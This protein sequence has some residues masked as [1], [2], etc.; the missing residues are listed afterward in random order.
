MAEKTILKS[1]ISSQKKTLKLPGAIGDWTTYRPAK[2]LIKKVKS[3]LYG[4][5]RISREELNTVLLIHYRFIQQLLKRVKIDLGLSG[6]LLQ[7]QVEQVS[8][9]NFLR[10][11]G[12]AIV[13]GQLALPEKHESI[14]FFLDLN[15]ANS[16]INHALGSRDLDAPPRALTEAEVATLTIALNEYLPLFSKTFKDIFPP[17]SFQYLSSPDAGIDPAF[18]TS[19]TFI[20]FSAEL[21]LNDNPAGKIIF[22]YQGQALKRLIKNYQEKERI[23]PLDL[24]RLPLAILNKIIVPIK[25]TLGETSLLTSEIS[26]LEVG[27]VVSLDTS[28]EEA[29]PLTIGKNL[30]VLAQ[31]GINRRKKAVKILGLTDEYFSFT[32]PSKISNEEEL[33][34]SSKKK[35]LKP[36]PLTSLAAGSAEAVQTEQPTT[37]P[38]SEETF[39]DEDFSEE[40]F[41]ET[42]FEDEEEGKENESVDFSGEDDDFS[43]EEDFPEEEPK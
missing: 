15:L 42:S 6:E 29:I 34:P 30:K 12:T 1:E 37:L 4:F 17:P 9:L 11:L 26:Q 19:A 10:S 31:P 3:G 5:D 23:A 21:T 14:A 25:A 16:L 24:S 18:N 7:C 33:L 36:S 8:Y 28:I 35:E 20:A 27:D 39:S 13:Q 38:A 43:L 32:P 22:G 41:S 40:D 2:V